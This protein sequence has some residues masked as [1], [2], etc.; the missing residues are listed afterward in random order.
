MEMLGIG[1]GIGASRLWGTLQTAAPDVDLTLVVNTGDDIWMHGLR[2]CPDLDTVIY[3]LSGRQD[4]ERG[5]GVRGE[6]WRS[7]EA[8]QALGVE[9]WF[10]LGDVDLATHLMRTGELRHSVPLSEVTRRLA[11]NLGVKAT[12]LPSTD[13][14]VAT[15]AITHEY[16]D[17]HYE[18][19]LVRYGAEPAVIASMTGGISSA[20]PAPAVLEAIAQS[21]VIVI[22]PSNPIA[23][24]APVLCVPGVREA[25]QRARAT[26]IAVTP[27]VI[28][29]PIGDVG[30]DR[31]ARSRAAL[32]E[33]AGVA[34]NP[35]G[36]AGLYKRLC[37]RMVIDSADIEFAATIRDQG[38]EVAAVPTLMHRGY[39][40][41][42]LMD[43][44]LRVALQSATGATS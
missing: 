42:Q 21:D 30:E 10:G 16:G 5:W 24:T 44:L 20:R 8:L 11:S 3:A 31:R 28:N 36:V 41:E 32:L 4:L 18:E 7:H 38:F 37:D 34:P 13:D 23:S 29:V 12:V 14:E 25:I 19:Y 33:A 17:I 27:I 39:P 2:I 15:R 9:A 43:A 22:G 1:G 26:V 40:P 6:T 35:V